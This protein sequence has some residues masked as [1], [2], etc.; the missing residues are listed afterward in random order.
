MESN[1]YKIVRTI[2]WK[3]RIY[4]FALVSAFGDGTINPDVFLR[5]IDRKER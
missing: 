5:D 1:I 2:R 3:H 4:R